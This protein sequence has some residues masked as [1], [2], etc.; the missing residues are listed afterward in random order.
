MESRP[1]PVQA[2][3][4]AEASAAQP[5][6]PA[7]CATSAGT[8]KS[9]IAEEPSTNSKPVDTAHTGKS[10]DPFNRFAGEKKPPQIDELE[11]RIEELESRLTNLPYDLSKRKS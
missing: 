4:V 6:E 8:T 7:A 2:Q 9:S 10:F 11:T 3:P 1:K 5:V